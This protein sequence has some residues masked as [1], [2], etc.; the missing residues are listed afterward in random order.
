MFRLKNGAE[1]GVRVEATIWIQGGRCGDR[2]DVLRFQASVW[3]SGKF[4]SINYRDEYVLMCVIV[5]SNN[6]VLF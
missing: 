4:I 6:G 1:S 2:L 3:M 5:K